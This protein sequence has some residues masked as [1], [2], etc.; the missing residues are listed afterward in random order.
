VA[1]KLLIEDLVEIGPLA[2]LAGVAVLFTGGIVASIVVDR[3]DPDSDRK[4]EERGG[5]TSDVGRGDGDE[6][7]E[8]TGP[9]PAER[10]GAASG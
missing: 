9:E 8:G 4:R 3:R 1:V 10:E 6:G 5:R 7:P 2:T